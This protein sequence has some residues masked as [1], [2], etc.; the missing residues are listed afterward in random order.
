MAEDSGAFEL[1]VELVRT[2]AVEIPLRRL[3]KKRTNSSS[4][5]ICNPHLIAS[6]LSN[7]RQLEM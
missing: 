6:L 1:L 4:E 2:K 5:E 3:A 7:L